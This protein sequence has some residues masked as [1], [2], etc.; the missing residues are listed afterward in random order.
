MGDS[1]GEDDF[2]YFGSSL[3]RVEE[4]KGRAKRDAADKGL[5]KVPPPWKQEVGCLRIAPASPFTLS[6]AHFPGLCYSWPDWCS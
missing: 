5:A 2:V 1:E 3:Q 4:L 6:G